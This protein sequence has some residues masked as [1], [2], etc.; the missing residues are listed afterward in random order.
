MKK[1]K[2]VAISSGAFIFCRLSLAIL[3]WIAFIFH[4]K[5][6][7]IL[8]FVIF[9]LSAIFKIKK[10]PM[11]LLYNYT[12]G[13]LIKS[14]EEILNEKAMFFAHT[15]GSVFS[16]ICLFLLYF[17]NER[18]GWAAV[19]IFALLKSISAF[20]FCPASKLYECST[21]DS[22]CAFAKKYVR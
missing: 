21:N 18:V 8:V 16:L 15:V 9:L 17:V 11:I 4:S 19:F 14:R 20:G 6:V 1:Y 22:C 13:K 12:L 5:T 10:A 7:L 3:V 2:P